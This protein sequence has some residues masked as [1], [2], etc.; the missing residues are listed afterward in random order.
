MSLTS[1]SL[2]LTAVS[3]DSRPVT[4]AVR[5]DKQTRAVMFATCEAHLDGALVFS[6]RALFAG[7]E[8]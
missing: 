2:E 8:S 1:L 6:A 5:I 7:S 4:L 3:L